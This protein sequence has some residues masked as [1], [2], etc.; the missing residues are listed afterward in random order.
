M[1]TE[2]QTFYSDLKSVLEKHGVSFFPNYYGEQFNDSTGEHESGYYEWQ[3]SGL[4]R[5][6]T[7]EELNES[8]GYKKAKYEF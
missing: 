3:I 4:E 2:L 8:M 7:L 5:T 1:E 6:W